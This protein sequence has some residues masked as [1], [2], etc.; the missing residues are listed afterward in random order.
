[1]LELRLLQWLALC[2]HV[3]GLP[4]GHAVP[5]T[6]LC[7]QRDDRQPRRVIEGRVF[8]DDPEGE[9][10]QCVRRENG[11]RLIE[12]LVR[13]RAA[14][15]EIVV[16]HRGEIVVYERESVQEFDRGRWR[17]ECVRISAKGFACC[18]NEQRPDA[19]PAGQNTI[20]HR[21]VQPGWWQQ[22]VGEP[23]VE[24]RFDALAPIS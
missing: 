2:R 10:L 11:G 15:S 12:S 19:L 14:T 24:T 20:A 13:R 18:I 3:D 21:L 8:R 17:I 5:S 22:D 7:Q 16:V 1:M 23:V 9:R 6:G 4:A